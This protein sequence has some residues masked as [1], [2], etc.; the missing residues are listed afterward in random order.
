MNAAM[1]PDCV[2]DFTTDHYRSL[3]GR[4]LGTGYRIVPFRD[5]A[6][7]ETH[8]VMILRHDLDHILEPA[9]TFAEL[10]AALGV[11]AT[12]F[13]QTACEFYNIL[14]PAGRA[15]IRR[16]CDLGHEIGLH[17]VSQRYVGPDSRANLRSDIR[18]LEDLSGQRIVSAAQHIPIDGE[19]V[20]L[21]PEIR[22]E[23]Y[24]P[25]YM[26]PPMGYISDSLMAWRQARPHDLVDQGKSFQFLTHPE[27]WTESGG[28][29]GTLLHRLMEREIRIVRERY[30]A[31]GAYYESLLADRHRRDQAFRERRKDVGQPERMKSKPGS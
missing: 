25:R 20:S 28:D 22:I 1:Q 18:L 14:A 31:T 5:F 11:R 16:L 19:F 6:A 24:E 27:N 23:A 2:T 8:P 21:A 4:A 13:V 15:I 30:A 29:I 17:Y 12:Y 10:E 26:A 9:V 7:V 3:L